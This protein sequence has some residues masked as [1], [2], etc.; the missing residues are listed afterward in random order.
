MTKITL[1]DGGLG[2]EIS[3]RSKRDT[4]PLWSVKVM[5]DDPD[6]VTEAHLDFIKA[7]ARV[8]SLN[9]YTATPT[10]MLRQGAEDGLADRLA[11]AHDV[12]ITLAQRAVKMA[13]NAPSRKVQ[14]AGCIPPLVASFVAEVSK[15][16][17]ESLLEFRTLVDLQ[18]HAV[19][20]FMIET[21][22][23][24]AEATA[25]LDAAK[26][27]ALPVYVSLTLSDDASNRLR[28]GERLED[29]IEALLAKKPNGIMLNCSMPE[30]ITKAMP[31]LSTAGIR[32]GG[33]ANGFT[34]IDQLKP[35]S[36]VD[37]LKARKDLTPEA[38]SNYV[39]QWI[40]H[41]ATIVGGCC[42]VGPDHIRYLANR[43]ESLGHE[44]VNFE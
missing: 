12:A 5:F 25:A 29:A 27:T 41:G 16:Y 19:D 10:R 9:T 11:E 6:I 36:T 4:H 28:S 13:G 40:D 17:A 38:Y 34:S 14:I 43:L 22:T 44:I 30:A 3:K 23:N 24:I 31:V 42:E 39:E 33:Y 37:V 35:G 32:F 8:I 2:Q 21:M 20:L 15:N 1:L 26:E 18:K 7:G